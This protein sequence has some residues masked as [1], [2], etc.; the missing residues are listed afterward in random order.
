MRAR[1]PLLNPKPPDELVVCF[2]FQLID[3]VCFIS[4]LSVVY[5][6]FFGY[7]LDGFYMHLS[8]LCCSLLGCWLYV[9]I[10]L[11]GVVLS[12][13]WLW[14]INSKLVIDN[15]LSFVGFW[16]S[17][18][19]AMMVSRACLPCCLPYWYFLWTFMIMVHLRN[20]V[21]LIC[22]CVVKPSIAPL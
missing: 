5:G 14:C 7:L 2:G 10:H 16:L 11:Y 17:I 1:K 22:G 13:M 21:H 19:L 4:L 12:W 8:R 20:A 18:D 9:V 15:G 6:L 3:V